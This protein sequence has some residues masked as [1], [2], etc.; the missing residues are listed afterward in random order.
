[1]VKL[2][3]ISVRRNMARIVSNY[4]PQNDPDPIFLPLLVDKYAKTTSRQQAAKT[5]PHHCGL[6]MI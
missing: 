4:H 6:V 1:M 5:K 2:G 3:Q